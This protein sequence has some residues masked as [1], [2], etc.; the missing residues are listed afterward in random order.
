MVVNETLPMCPDLVLSTEND[1]SL[2]EPV[3]VGPFQ[4]GIVFVRLLDPEG[5]P[6]VDAK[7]G[8][9]PS[10]YEDWDDHWTCLDSLSGLEE[11]GIHALQVSNF[12][13][14]LRL[15]FELN[16]TSPEDQVTVLAWFVGDG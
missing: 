6:V 14:W 13:N 4:Q 2:S 10:G 1:A 8:I 12:G 16:D 7:V 9:S 11:E 5:E 15:K 3:E